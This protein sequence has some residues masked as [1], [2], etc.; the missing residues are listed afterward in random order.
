MKVAEEV[1][2]TATSA[3][4]TYPDGRQ[5][6]FRENA[7][8]TFQSPPGMHA[9]FGKQSGGGWRLMDKAATTYLF[10]VTGRL[11]K[12]TDQRGRS[13]ELTYGSDGK[14]AKV[15]GVGGRS[16]TFTWQDGHVGTVSSDPVDGK[17]LTWTYSYDGDRL[18][19]VCAPV[20][21]PNCTTYEYGGGSLYRS[22]VLDSDPFGY[23][24]LG[25]ATGKAIDLGWGAGD[26]TYDSTAKRAQPD[27]LAGTSDQHRGTDPERDR[28]EDRRLRVH[29]GVVQDQLRRHGHV[30]AHCPRRHQGG[31][32]RG[33][34]ETIAA[35]Q[36]RYVTTVGGL[37]GLVDEVAIYDRPLTG[38]EV[39]QHHA[40]RTGAGHRLTKVTLPSERV[41]AIN[42]YDDTTDR[43]ATHTDTGGG[44]WKIGAI[45]IEQES[46]EAQVTVTDPDNNSLVYLYDAWRGYRIRG[47]TDQLGYTTWHEYDQAGFLT[48][49]IDKNDIANEI[50]QDER[51]NTL[52]RQ[53]CRA[54]GECAIEFWSYYLNEDDPFDPRN[55]QVTAY[56][57]G[58]SASDT[59][60]AFAT[61]TEYNSFGEQTKVT[62]PATED[63]PQGRSQ[64]TAY[65][66]GTEEAAGGGTTP[67]G[68]AKR[69][70]DARGNTWI[71]RY[72]AAGDLAEQIDPE[73]LITKLDYDPIGRVIANTR[74]S[75]AVPDGAKTT[76]AY[77]GWNR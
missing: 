32:V 59:D 10:D 72:T 43:I 54:A 1:R 36:N 71:Y 25:E 60:P 9:T 37:A 50:Y 41:W 35:T 14:L 77:D 48:K 69:R 17:A 24:R 34:T 58:R 53:Y 52:G 42:T 27:A 40:A 46:G 38:D 15:S 18:S 76:F 64:S 49:V 21:A 33:L 70:T 11:T 2:G 39:R 68:L 16:V 5:L 57:D 7:D 30:A 66:D 20:T 63:F 75:E 28:P 13:S 55:D 45:G 61:T 67:A 62:S 51:G 65:T 29:G 22:S 74:I 4:V 56:R 31:G 23:W 44:T 8:G 47:E 26:A 3:L 73:G 6:R 19:Q 12:I